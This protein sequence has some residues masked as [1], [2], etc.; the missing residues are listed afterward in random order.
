M[1]IEFIKLAIYIIL[2]IIISKYMLVKLLRNIAETLNLKAK[3]VGNIAGFATSIPEL[4]TV[5]LASISGLASTSLYNIIS[6]NVIN[7]IQYLATVI[8]NKNTKV[9]KNKALII[10]LIIVLITIAIPLYMINANVKLGVPFAIFLVILFLFFYKINSN[11]HK[12]YLEKYDKEIVKE[13]EL[14]YKKEIKNKKNNKL[15]IIK[16]LIYLIIIGI[17]LYFVG[18]KLSNNLENLCYIFNVPEY[19]I[20]IILGFGTSIPEL[21]TFFEAQR[22]EKNKEEEKLGVIEATNNLLMSNVLNLFIIQSIGISIFSI[23]YG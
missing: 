15:L 6:S 12:L 18:D 11:A 16:Y 7:L 2:I 8:I 1:F 17:L 10:D 5:T 3:T 23:M 19:I 14:E 21:I 22:G 9:L 13:F 4:F 20:G